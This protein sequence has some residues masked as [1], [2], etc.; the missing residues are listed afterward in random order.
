[1][2]ASLIAE[3]E[4][5]GVLDTVDGQ[6]ALQLARQVTA[7]GATGV[8]SLSKEF[9]AV[10]ADALAQGRRPE[11]D[12]QPAEPA[13]VDEVEEARRRRDAKTRAAAAAGS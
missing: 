1:M 8:S 10:R 2:V 13:E 3:L 5:F 11:P 6:L 12:A 4:S 9:R 7:T